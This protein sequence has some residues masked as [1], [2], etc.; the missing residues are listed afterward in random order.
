MKP[1]VILHLIVGLLAGLA[2]ALFA[3]LLQAQGAGTFAAMLGAQRSSPLLWVIDACALSVPAGLVWAA[4]LIDQFQGF[5]EQQADQHH[6]QLIGMI[7]RA[8]ELEQV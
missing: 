4:R 5:V 8:N 7:E 2:L 6:E 1:R 3:T